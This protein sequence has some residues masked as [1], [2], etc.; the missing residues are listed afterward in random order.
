MDRL[1][2][3]LILIIIMLSIQLYD[4]LNDWT[5]LPYIRYDV[6]LVLYIVMLV[7][8]IKLIQLYLTY[9]PPWTVEIIPI[10]PMYILWLWIWLSVFA[11]KLA[12][13]Y[14]KVSS[15]CDKLLTLRFLV[16][17]LLFFFAY[18]SVFLLYHLRTLGIEDRKS[19]LL[20]LN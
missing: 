1:D 9:M 8:I 19:K 4:F 5:R 15:T 16:S 2:Y 3:N 12:F 18:L 17:L 10:I 7:Y 14:Y 13:H 6:I 11:G 20:F